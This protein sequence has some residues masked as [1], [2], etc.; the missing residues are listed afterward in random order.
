MTEKSEL[1]ST[2]LG[3][4]SHEI[5]NSSIVT[6]VEKVPAKEG[7]S[8]SHDTHQFQEE[9]IKKGENGEEKENKNVIEI[10]KEK[11]KKSEIMEE[12]IHQNTKIDQEKQ[13]TNTNIKEEKQKKSEIRE[14]NLHENK[15]GS[16]KVKGNE[17]IGN[18]MS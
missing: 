15:G 11:H 6:N 4:L 17:L 7:E 12:N 10:E 9:K 13:A 3:S 16:E 18:G 5:M 1:S 8:H 14:E 2:S